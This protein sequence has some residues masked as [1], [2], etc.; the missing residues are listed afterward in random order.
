MPI[1]LYAVPFDEN[2]FVDWLIDAKAGDRA[3]YYRGYLSYDR[4]PSAHVLERPTRA[5]LHAVATRVMVAASQGLVIP[6]QQRIGSE[7]YLYLAVKA[8]PGRVVQNRSV[9]PQRFMPRPLGMHAMPII[10]TA[11]AA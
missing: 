4:M 11:L 7:D 10:H 5:N 1:D 3:V 8:Q 2:S 6:V 9:P